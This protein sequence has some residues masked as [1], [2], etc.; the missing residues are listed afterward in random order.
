MYMYTTTYMCTY[1]SH[2][3]HVHHKTFIGTFRYI[4]Y[5][6]NKVNKMKCKHVNTKMITFAHK[7][8]MSL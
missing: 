4:K 8:A 5:A 2:V 3:G 1:I 7:Y 6:I